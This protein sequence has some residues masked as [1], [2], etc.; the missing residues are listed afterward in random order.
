MSA[1]L[2]QQLQRTTPLEV[3]AVV[4]G[5]AYVLL[6]VRRNR[7]GWFAGAASSSIYVYLAARARLPMQSLL[8]AYYVA[9]AVY[10]WLQWTRNAGEQGGRIVRLALRWHLH[11]VLLILIASAL[12]ARWLAAETQAAWPWLD[13]LTTWTCLWA[14]WLVARSV[15]ENWLYWIAA[16][17]V[18]VFL[19]AQQ[20]LPFTAGLFTAYLL[21]ASWG[22][23]TWLLRYR[24]QMH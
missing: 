24:R 21:I 6:I 2:W 8:Q 9:M 13:S 14:T 11:A 16:D 17:A 18:S 20:S 15:L 1:E 7:W 22:Y 19:F 23:R 5:L 10:G 12:T 3:A 4:L